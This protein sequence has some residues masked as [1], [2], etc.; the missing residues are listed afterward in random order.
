MWAKW[1][2]VEKE[3]TAI[4]E[5]VRKWAHFFK[6]QNLHI[7]NGSTICIFYFWQNDHRK[8]KNNK[9]LLWRLELSQFDYEIRHKPGAENVASDALSRV[10]AS[11]N[12]HDRLVTLHNSLGHPGYARLYHLVRV[13]NLPFTSEEV[14][15]VCRQCMA[16][17]EIKPRFHRP[18][19]Q[20]LVKATRAWDRLS[21]DF[22]GPLKGSKPYLFVVV[23]EY[24]RFPFAFPCKTMTSEI[25][26]DCLS[27]LFSLFGFPAYI[28][29]DRGLA[30]VS[31]ELKDF[32]STRGIACLLYTSDAADD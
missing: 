14:K 19:P 21:I 25:V 5:A 6:G 13:R 15:S 4:T 8:I 30:F 26:V 28:H 32:L 17:A 1:S 2:I 16:C 7:V 29:S 12:S 27:K 3:A 20:T 22:K 24:S 23:D 31:R 9:I 18:E 10:C 11:S